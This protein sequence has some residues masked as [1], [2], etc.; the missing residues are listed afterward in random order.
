MALLVCKSQFH[1]N[2]KRKFTKIAFLKRLFGHIFA[3]QSRRLLH[4]CQTWCR[5]QATKCKQV[6]EQCRGK[7]VICRANTERIYPYS[8][9]TV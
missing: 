2:R 7:S 8:V 1:R 4:K 5:T 3:K 9:C 6:P